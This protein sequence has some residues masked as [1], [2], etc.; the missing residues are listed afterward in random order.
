MH[1]FFKK[2]QTEEKTMTTPATTDTATPAT[3]VKSA[4][5]ES[6][7]VSLKGIFEKGLDYLVKE[8]ESVGGPELKIILATL[9]NVFKAHEATLESSDEQ[10]GSVRNIFTPAS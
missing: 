9:Q 1:N 4:T 5:A 6:V 2:H 3:P 7:K 10:L 8:G